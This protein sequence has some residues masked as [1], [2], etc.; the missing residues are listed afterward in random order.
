VG[1]WTYFSVINTNGSADTHLRFQCNN[2]AAGREFYIDDI[3]LTPLNVTT[4]HDRTRRGGRSPTQATVTRRPV[5]TTNDTPSGKLTLV[6]NG[7]SMLLVSPA[8]AFDQPNSIFL[9]SHV[10]D[11][12]AAQIYVN[13]RAAGSQ[14]YTSLADGL[15]KLTNVAAQIT[16]AYSD[17]WNSVGMVSDGAN[18]ILVL[19]NGLSVSGNSGANNWGGITIGASPLLGNF[20]V[21]RF[22]TIF[23]MNRTHTQWEC[24]QMNKSVMRRL[25]I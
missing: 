15:L 17:G 3:L 16:V 9:S 21:G 18:S 13:S 6:F 10:T 4:L 5:L 14:F 7:T 2:F 8:F 1:A 22:N 19:G 20:C 12:A 23:G 25:G 24:Y 11:V